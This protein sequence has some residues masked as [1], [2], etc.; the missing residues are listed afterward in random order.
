M[1]LTYQQ[2]VLQLA[3]EA[4]NMLDV[5][6]IKAEGK[7]LMDEGIICD[8]FEGNAPY[9][10]RYILPDYEKFM[11]NGSQFLDIKPPQ[12]LLEAV[13]S[14]LI[15]YKH[16]PS[17]TSFP[18][19]LGEIDKLLEPFL[20][21]EDEEHSYKVI[22]LFLT[23]IDRTLT[24]S[25]VHANIGPEETKA[26]RL[27]LRAER[28]LKNAVP[29]LSLK[30]SKETPKEFA[31]LA[32][33]TALEASKPYFANHSMFIEDF[34][35]EYGLASCYNGL[36]IGGGSYTLA[37]LNLKGLAEKADNIEDYIERQIPY[38]V[39]EM[40]DIMDKRIDFLVEESGF[41]DSSF[42]VREGLLSREK[43]TAMFGIF[44][45]AEAVNIL[46]NSESIKDKFGH[47]QE[48]N[49]LGVKII[50]K[51]QEEVNNHF[52]KYCIKTDSK[53]LLHAQSGISSDIGISPG[54]RIPIGDEPETYDHIL[55]ASKF[56]KFFPSGVS[57]IFKFEST[58]KNNP[59]FI[60]D[61]I[62]GAMD[63]GMRMFS[64]HTSDS[65]L[66]RITGYLVKKSEMDR[67]KSGKQALQDTVALGLESLEKQNILGRKVRRND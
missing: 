56:H 47:S 17:I 62:N 55:Q 32:I 10:P 9:R 4:E 11:I 42:L 52:N 30:Y 48:A 18:V 50:E 5:L 65:D 39:K 46:L 44:G 58:V 36:P 54:C 14:L 49:N 41:F 43:F 16:V 26:G 63:N 35:R 33:K 28:E 31:H 53:F 60:L 24:D 22:K 2:K 66:V 25:F 13:N 23:H 37:R 45:L 40:A 12:D 15:L 57:D 1:S 3:R 6:D 34:G 20:E 61:I 64:F 7:K 38:A 27:I 29:N 59:D 8:L 19:F 67:L 21:E 51:L